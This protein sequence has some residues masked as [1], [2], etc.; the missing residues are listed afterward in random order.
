MKE[1]LP[2]HEEFGWVLFPETPLQPRSEDEGHRPFQSSLAQSKFNVVPLLSLEITSTLRYLA[3]LPSF[4]LSQF[5]TPPSREG[6]PASRR[7]VCWNRAHHTRLLQ[8]LRLERGTTGRLYAGSF[9]RSK[10]TFTG[11]AGQ[12]GAGRPLAKP[13]LSP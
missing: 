10:A 11:W 7:K 12:R 4:S 8:T 1:T 2:P 6:R 3:A 5:P 13:P 9:T